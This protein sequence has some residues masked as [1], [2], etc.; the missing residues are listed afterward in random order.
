V[1]SLDTELAWGR[2]AESNQDSYYPLFEQTRVVINRLLD[3]F[4][5]YEV[6]A[7]WAVVGRMIEDEDNPSDYFQEDLSKYFP[8]INSS[9]IYNSN[10]LNNSSNSYVFYKEVIEQIQSAK[11]KHE[12]GTHSYNHIVFGRFKDKDLAERDISN[13]VG[14]LNQYGITTNS[15]V[16]PRNSIAYK[17]ALMKNGIQYYRGPDKLWYQSFPTPIAKILGLVDSYL[18]IRAAVVNPTTTPEGLVNI[19]GS[20]FYRISHKGV[21]KMVPISVLT[22]KAILALDKAAATDSIFH[23]WFHPFNFA[24]KLEEHF[25]GFETVLAHAKKLR[26]ANK[27]NTETMQ[28]IGSKYKAYKMQKALS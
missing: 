21:K 3:L 25:Q 12:I 11:V 8:S 26:S 4:D 28:Q 15:M 2:I 7:T 16:Y 17:E 20:L 9:S 6:P 10:M 14:I 23:L 19:P 27:I 5:K 13:A 18:P 1:I 24:H 22:R